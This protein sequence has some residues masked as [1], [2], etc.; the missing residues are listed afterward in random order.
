MKRWIAASVA[1]ILITFTSVSWAGTTTD[2]TK[3]QTLIESWF[4]A[5]KAQ[6]TDKAA[7]FL[8]PQFVS[9]HTDGVVRNK[10]QEIQ[11]M[12]TLNIGNYK[13]TDFTFSQ[14]TNIIT[15]TYKDQTSETIDMNAV[16]TKPAGRMAVLQKQGA[17]WLIVA[18]ANLD[19]IK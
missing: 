8:A 11:L 10:E 13:L 7:S 1:A 19:T 2:T 15:V 3:A 12:K 14:S 6:Q 4:A 17:D 18:Y 5:M 9:I 16:G